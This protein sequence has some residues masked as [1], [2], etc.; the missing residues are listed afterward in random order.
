MRAM[1]IIQIEEAKL[2]KVTWKVTGNFRTKA[3]K[4]SCKMVM[5]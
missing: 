5:K 1:E 4:W 3:Q 2:D